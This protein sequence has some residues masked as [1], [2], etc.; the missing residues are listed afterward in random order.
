MSESQPPPPLPRTKGRLPFDP[1]AFSR[2]PK[3]GA[4]LLVYGALTIGLA[5]LAAYMALVEQ[6]P[7]ASGYVAGSPRS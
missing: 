2:A 4:A 3:Q 7:L 1:N 5:G 6:R